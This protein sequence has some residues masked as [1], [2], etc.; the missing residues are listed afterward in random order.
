MINTDIY[1][2]SEETPIFAPQRL[3]FYKALGVAAYTI[4]KVRASTVFMCVL[5]TFR[6]SDF[7]L[8][9]KNGFV[10]GARTLNVTA[11]SAPAIVSL[12]RLARPGDTIYS[13]QLL[14][15]HHTRCTLNYSAKAGRHA[16]R[17]ARKERGRMYDGKVGG[18]EGGR[19]GREGREGGEGGREGAKGEWG[20][21]SNEMAW[22]GGS[23]SGGREGRLRKGTSEEGMD[24]ANE[25]GKGGRREQRSEGEEKGRS[26]GGREIG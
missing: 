8:F 13:L 16:G 26:V 25:R 22:E 6:S 1:I 3:P 7:L 10:V 19:V 20:G 18:R 2:I 4:G 5:C 15:R 24:G 23:G 9:V 14:A 21:R 11:A 12:P 17:E